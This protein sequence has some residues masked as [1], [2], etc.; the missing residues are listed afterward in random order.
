MEAPSWLR[1]PPKP[2]KLEPRTSQTKQVS[3][4]VLIEEFRSSG[5]PDPEKIATTIFR[6]REH[7]LQLKMARPTSVVLDTEPKKTGS[8]IEVT[9]CKAKTLEGKQC[10]FKAVCNGFCKKH[11]VRTKISV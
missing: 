2:Y 1:V 6:A 9:K 11:A 4:E 5:H 8:V 10:G 7:A 3:R